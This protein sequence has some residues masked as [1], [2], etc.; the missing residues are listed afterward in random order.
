[1]AASPSPATAA[2]LG[3]VAHAQSSGAATP[4]RLARVVWEEYRPEE[5]SYES[6]RDRMFRAAVGLEALGMPLEEQ[7]L[8]RIDDAD[9]ELP[10]LSRSAANYARGSNGIDHVRAWR[11]L[12]ANWTGDFSI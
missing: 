8:T 12:V 5:E 4:T 9:P 11:A 10:L 7:E 1:M 3:A 6:W 2:S